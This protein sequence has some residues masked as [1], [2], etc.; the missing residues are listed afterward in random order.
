MSVFFQQPNDKQIV[1]QPSKVEQR[2][3]NENNAEASKSTKKNNKTKKK[4]K[5]DSNNKKKK[6]KAPKTLGTTTNNDENNVLCEKLNHTHV[7]FQFD[8]YSPPSIGDAD[9]V[10]AVVDATQQ[11]KLQH[12]R[13]I[14]LQEDALVTDQISNNNKNDAVHTLKITEANDLNGNYDHLPLIR[15]ENHHQHQSESN[16]LTRS[17]ESIPF[18]DD[19]ESNVSRSPRMYPR[20]ET[21]IITLIPKNF[22]SHCLQSRAAAATV[23]VLQSFKYQESPPKP[24]RAAQLHIL[25]KIDEQKDDTHKFQYYYNPGYKV[26]QICHLYLHVCPA[27]KCFECEFVV[28]Q[29]CFEK[30][31]STIYFHLFFF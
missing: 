27:I 23:P 3:N 8:D 24:P 30:V 20:F 19:V 28:H 2:L 10:V 7:Q 29:Q 25:P 13:D 14:I 18:I 1:I 22:E 17:N 4:A 16:T 12:A 26:C 5:V 11:E 6:S 31:S 21:R 9:D 15:I